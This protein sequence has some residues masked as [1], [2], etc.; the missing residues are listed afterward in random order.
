MVTAILKRYERFLRIDPAAPKSEI[1]RARAVY[2]ISWAFIASQALNLVFMS[3]SYGE[4]TFDHT[5]SVTV[6]AIIFC[7][8]QTL[9]WTKNFT[10]FSTFFALLIF[11]GIMASALPDHTGINSALLPIVVL[12]SVACGFISGWRACTVYGLCAVPFLGFLYLY[13]QGAPSYDLINQSVF[14]ARTFQR[15]VQAEIALG[16]VTVIGSIFSANMHNA[17]RQLERRMHAIEQADQAKTN[18]LATMSHELCT[19]LNGILGISEVLNDSPLT[20]DQKELTEI[21][22]QSSEDM[23]GLIRDVLDFSLIESGRM[24]PSLAP[25]HLPAI[26]GRLREQYSSA[27]AAK[28]IDLRV[29]YDPTLPQHFMAD[30]ATLSRALGHLLDNAIKF[31]PHGAV[32]VSVF[33]HAPGADGLQDLSISFTDT[34]LGIAREDQARIFEKFEQGDKSTTRAFG[35]TGLGLTLAHHMIKL[36][37]GDITVKSDP[38]QGSTFTVRLKLEEIAAPQKTLRSAA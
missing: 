4:W 37:G 12:G 31:T 29:Q 18:F 38:G 19:P 9:R 10:L 35:G 17:F 32:H 1:M 13:S 2:Y 27:A 7:L 8:A 36:M 20:A 16:L 11:S 15:L 5:I 28:H 21:L 14:E 30:P 22:V 26:L 3:Y 33:G 34:G 25:C 23:N 6:S 24:Q